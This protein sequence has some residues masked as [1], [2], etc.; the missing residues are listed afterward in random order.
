[1]IDVRP[2][3]AGEEDEVQALLT[4]A[5]RPYTANMVP[6]LYDQYLKAVLNTSDGQVLVAVSDDR[7]VGSA[8]LYLAGTPPV[9]VPAEWA[10]VRAVGVAPSARGAGVGRALM[11]YSAA[12]SGDAAAL[13]L[14]TMDFM[15]TAVRLYERLGYERAPEWDLYIGRK[16][17]F[18]P[19]E[20][21][22]A[23]AYRVHLSQVP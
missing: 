11:E 4:E 9:P 8:R 19:E 12:H 14:H 18:P 3:R 6:T 20:T 5:Y 17:G 16:A 22:H 21:V 23:L 10:W 7:I 13:S 1:M 15:P 2:M